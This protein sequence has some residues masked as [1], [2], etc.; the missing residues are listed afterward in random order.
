MLTMLALPV[1]DDIYAMLDFP[2]KPTKRL[3]QIARDL[4]I[5][6]FKVFGDGQYK[7]ETRVALRAY[8]SPIDPLDGHTNMFLADEIMLRDPH[9]ATGLML[10]AIDVH[11]DQMGWKNS[12]SMWLDEM[13]DF[14]PQRYTWSL[15]RWTTVLRRWALSETNLETASN[16][17]LDIFEQVREHWKNSY[18][19]EQVAPLPLTTGTRGKLQAIIF[20]QESEFLKFR[21]KLDDYKRSAK[22]A[23]ERLIFSGG[24]K[25]HNEGTYRWDLRSCQAIRR[26]LSNQEI[27]ILETWV[28][29]DSWFLEHEEAKFPV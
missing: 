10:S 4:S 26:L 5:A 8:K 24:S 29:H 13:S 2:D 25:I 19:L 23:L 20:Q 12:I 27:Q 17:E 28:S 9:E 14:Q 3:K 21:K 15:L 22:P 1:F 16:D 11:F 7:E 18:D 6:Y